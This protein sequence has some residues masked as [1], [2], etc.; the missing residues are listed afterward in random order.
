MQLAS[1]W[2]YVVAQFFETLHYKSRLRIRFPVVSSEF[3][4]GIILPAALCSWGWL[5]L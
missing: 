4:V 3:F 5:S 1:S 2:G